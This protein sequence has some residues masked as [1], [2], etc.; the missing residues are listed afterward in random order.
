MGRSSGVS[1]SSLIFLSRR[2]VRH[3]YST[4]SIACIF[5]VSYP[6]LREG[7]LTTLYP[8]ENIVKILEACAEF[9]G[10]IE[11]AGISSNLSLLSA[12]RLTK[13]IYSFGT[14]STDKIITA[15]QKLFTNIAA[16]I[17][18]LG[19]ADKSLSQE[20][21]STR[22]VTKSDTSQ[23]AYEI[24]A[25]V[26]QDHRCEVPEMYAEEHTASKEAIEDGNFRRWCTTFRHEETQCTDEMIVLLSK[27][28]HS[29]EDGDRRIFWRVRRLGEQGIV[30]QTV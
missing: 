3:F 24:L 15:W 18:K 16:V 11:Q 5:Q 9:F 4:L 22:P 26:D 28:A 19:V 8:D 25:L 1:Q 13:L 10:E 2:S 17:R 6:Y 30:S 23:T 27:I 14:V 7:T 29:R 20:A 21:D 12:L